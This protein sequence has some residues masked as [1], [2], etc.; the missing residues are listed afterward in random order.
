[1]QF[2]LIYLRQDLC[3]NA[4]R[5]N[6]ADVKVGDSI[7]TN[8]ILAEVETDKAVAEVPSTKSRRITSCFSRERTFA[9]GL[10]LFCLGES[11]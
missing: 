1:M 8:D 2:D 10:P 7:K 9:I 5:L 4:D 3:A 11:E 6:V